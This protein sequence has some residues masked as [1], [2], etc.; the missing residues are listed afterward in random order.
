MLDFKSWLNSPTKKLNYNSVNDIWKC[1]TKRQIWHVRAE[2]DKYAV[3]IDINILNYLSYLQDKDYNLIVNQS[4]QISIDL[5][6]GGQND[7]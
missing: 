2:L 5:Y 7:F 3:I 1:M 6:N 4:L